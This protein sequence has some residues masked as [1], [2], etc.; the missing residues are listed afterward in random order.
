MAYSSPPFI[1]KKI[2]MKNSTIVLFI[3][4][5]AL[6]ILDIV[7]LFTNVPLAFSIAFCVMNV[8]IILGSIPLF[9]Q[10]FKDRKYQKYLKEEPSNEL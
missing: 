9:I 5:I 7:A 10:E 4:W 3:I 1:K 6:A 2:D 8:T